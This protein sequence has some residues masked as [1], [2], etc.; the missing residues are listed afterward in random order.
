LFDVL[1]LGCV[2][3]DDVLYVPSFPK[4]DQK[5]RVE[6]DVRRFG[7]LTGAAL[8]AAA[9]LGVRCAYA[10]CLGKDESSQQVA[11][12]FAREGVNTDHA[13][14]FALGRVVR[15]T[16]VVGQDKGTRNVF[17][18]NDGRIGAHDRL[19]AAAVIRRSKVLLIDDYGMDGNLRAVG[20]ARSASVAVVAD[21]E[22]S[23]APGLE[24]VLAR[25][26]HL[27]VSEAFASSMTGKPSA[28]DAALALWRPDRAVVIVT[29]GK[30]GCYSVSVTG[31]QRASFHP[32]YQVR[33]ADTT[34]CGDVFHGAYAASLAKGEALE[35]R[36]LFASAA[37]ALNA[38]D[39]EIPRRVTVEEFLRRTP[40]PARA[41]TSITPRHHSQNSTRQKVRQQAI[42][43]L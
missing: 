17:Y 30:R 14:R 2:A 18:R 11:E 41:H 27:I 35:K 32:A 21:F 38:R 13:P 3:V 24:A 12:N 15:S 4:V 8:V 22:V 33:E 39:S 43:T 40:S 31:Q 26:D 34:G 25:V 19:P 37:A 36:I 28:P 6:H 10:G 23:T 7:G 9:R 29:C 42:P 16:I 1:G 20:L 5:L